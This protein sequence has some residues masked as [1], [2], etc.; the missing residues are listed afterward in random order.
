MFNICVCVSMC[1]WRSVCAALSRWLHRYANIGKG[2]MCNLL[3]P[4]PEQRSAGKKRQIPLK[5]PSAQSPDGSHYQRNAAIIPHHS[6]LPHRWQPSGIRLCLGGCQGL[7]HGLGET[8]VA[9]FEHSIHPCTIKLLVYFSTHKSSFNN[10]EIVSL[11]HW[12]PLHI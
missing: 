3:S 6:L 7:L 5:R 11:I 8:D 1:T 9:K 10:L 2:L 12:S 4:D